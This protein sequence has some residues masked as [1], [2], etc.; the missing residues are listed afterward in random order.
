MKPNKLFCLIAALIVL[1]AVGCKKEPKRTRTPLH[2][3]ARTGDIAQVKSLLAKGA[4]VNDQSNILHE[5]PLHEA[6]EDGY[7]DIV[8]EHHG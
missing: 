2:K 4:H 8:G 5:T 7:Q 6:A 3:A 1:V